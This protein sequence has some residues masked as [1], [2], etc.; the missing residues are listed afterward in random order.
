[1]IG[2]F[3]SG[4]GGLTVLRAFAKRL[5]GQEFVYLGDHANAPY[6]C[7]SS[8]EIVELTRRNVERL[9]QRGCR[10]VVLACNTAT[11]IALRTLQ[12]GWLP[13][14]YPDRRILGIVAPMVETV[15]GVPW[16]TNGPTAGSRQAP[17]LVAIFAT[18][19]TVASAV[20]PEEI[21]KR[22]P[23][24]EVVQ[25]A[26]PELAAAIEGHAATAEID[27][28]IHAYV[29]EA[30]ER[31]E[32]RL[33]NSAILGCTHYQLVAKSF[34]TALPSNVAL[35]DQPAL[36]AESLADYLRRRP[37]FATP[38]P[39]GSHPCLLTT[40]E[41]SRVTARAGQFLDSGLMFAHAG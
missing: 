32:G 35:Y 11:T 12:Q 7:R 5:P 13:Q 30:L 9:F 37:A 36:V 29:A 34:S 3:D 26:C 22:A 2:V 15:T 8:E 21:R 16:A 10:L 28:L 31:T 39:A 1:M 6:G 17:Y 14:A 38:A 24:V 23:A 18:R 27:G 33:P 4:F 25:Q 20:Y 40:G 19:R 41:V